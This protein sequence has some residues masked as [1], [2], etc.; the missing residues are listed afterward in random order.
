[1]ISS[2]W[3]QKIPWVGEDVLVWSTG[4]GTKNI[5]RASQHLGL[6]KKT[7]NKTENV[8][9]ALDNWVKDNKSRPLSSPTD[10]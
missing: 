5:W 2:S 10:F 3:M 6:K 4:S 1:M 7:K 9:I 8:G